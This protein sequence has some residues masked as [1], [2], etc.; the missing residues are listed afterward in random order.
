MVPRSVL[1]CLLTLV[2]L[3]VLAQKVSGAFDAVA[4][5]GG[6]SRHTGTTV[7]NEPPEALG[8]N[9]NVYKSMRCHL[10]EL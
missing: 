7:V 4:T 2:G 8:A 9:R 10:S 1:V 3:D 6:A 5:F